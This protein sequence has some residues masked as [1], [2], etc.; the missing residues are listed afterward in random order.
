MSQAAAT[1]S[2]IIQYEFVLGDKKS[3]LLCC[4]TKFNKRTVQMTGE[5]LSASTSFFSRYQKAVGGSPERADLENLRRY[6]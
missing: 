6:M 4:Y 1:V 3:L 5:R 2:Y